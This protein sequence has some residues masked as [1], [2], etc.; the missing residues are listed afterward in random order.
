MLKLDIGCGPLKRSGFTGI[1]VTGEPDIL[2][3]VSREKLPFDD[4]SADHV[5][6]SHCLEHIEYGRLLH[7]FSEMTRVC[8]Q[9][10]LIELWHPHVSHEDAYIFGHVNRLSESLYD[11][12]GCT[13]RSFWKNVFGGS[14]W[15]L[16][17]IRY[18]VDKSVLEEMQSRNIDIDFAVSFFRNVIREMGVFIR[19]DRTGMSGSSHYLRSVSLPWQRADVILPLLSG[20]RKRSDHDFLP[21]QLNAGGFF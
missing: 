19:V 8:A 12:L 16:Q 11:H 4:G 13:H 18:G 1:D 10:G 7:V 9:G 15:I 2:C 3:D 6:S 20:P 17:E 5:F 14:Q 21:D